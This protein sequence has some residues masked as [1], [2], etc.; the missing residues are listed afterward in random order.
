MAKT[1]ENI[2]MM[3]ANQ[4]QPSAGTQVVIQSKEHDPN[5]L[6]DKFHKR[7]AT[8]FYGNEGAIKADDWLE[9]IGDVFEI[10]TCDN[11]QRVVLATSMF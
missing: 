9:H 3:M 1:N 5:N 7:G 6:Y 2:A 8:Q 10:V 4:A 11:K